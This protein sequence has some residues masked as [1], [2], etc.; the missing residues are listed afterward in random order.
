MDKEYTV[1]IETT[2]NPIV[3]FKLAA[4]SAWYHKMGIDFSDASVF[5]QPATQAG[6]VQQQKDYHVAVDGTVT[7]W[8]GQDSFLPEDI[9]IS[10]SYVDPTHD[11]TNRFSVDYA[12]G[13]LFL[14][15]PI[16]NL[17]PGVPIPAGSAHWDHLASLA[18]SY[19]VAGYTVG[20]DVAIENN[21]YAYNASS[22]SVT[23][24]TENIKDWINKQVKI[25]WG[26]P[27][28]GETLTELVDYFSPV[29]S[30]V[31]FRFT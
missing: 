7:V 20:Y 21:N 25:I 13:L 4:G 23:V 8:V 14:S 15:Q 26:K 1:R 2:T 6:H 31:G 16:L 27:P 19:K 3:Q 18:V 22:N 12:R 29:V 17:P 11:P 30:H 28:G 5:G 24:R 9:T 10:Y